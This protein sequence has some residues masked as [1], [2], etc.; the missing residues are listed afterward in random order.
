MGAAVTGAPWCPGE[1]NNK[2][3]DEA[4]GALLTICS[5]DGDGAALVND[6]PCSRPLRVL[7]AFEAP[8]ECLEASNWTLLPAQ[9]GPGG[10][11]AHWVGALAYSDLGPRGLAVLD[12]QQNACAAF[13]AFQF[14]WKPAILERCINQALY[15]KDLIRTG[16]SA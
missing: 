8:A 9:S 2:N 14:I 5:G 13:N 12:F 6:F 10:G 3:G 16:P 7:C 11:C 4:C 15:L 1:P